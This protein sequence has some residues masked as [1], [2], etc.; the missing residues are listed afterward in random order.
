MLE[1][2]ISVHSLSR[3]QAEITFGMLNA[4]ALHYQV[5]LK[6]YHYIA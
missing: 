6:I 5:L 3:F 1:K 4:G 2:E